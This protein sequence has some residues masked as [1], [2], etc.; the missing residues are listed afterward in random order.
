ME[1]TPWQIAITTE[2]SKASPI[3]AATRK[4]WRSAADH[5][6]A[7]PVADAGM[8]LSMAIA[9][10]QYLHRSSVCPGCGTSRAAPHCRQSLVCVRFLCPIRVPTLSADAAPAQPVVYPKALHRFYSPR[11]PGVRLAAWVRSGRITLQRWSG[12]RCRSWPSAFQVGRAREGL[13]ERK[14]GRRVSVQN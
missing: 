11:L 13:L 4:F 1:A 14:R 12:R 10:P 2:L 9:T 5:R 7:V 6:R 8:G 3:T